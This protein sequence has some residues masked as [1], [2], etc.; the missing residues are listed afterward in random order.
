M[1][2]MTQVNIAATRIKIFFII[3]KTP[4]FNIFL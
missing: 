3:K 4:V 2:E 1:L